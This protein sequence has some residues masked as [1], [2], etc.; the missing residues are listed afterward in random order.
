LRGDIGKARR[1]MPAKVGK[2]LMAL[3]R[4][5]MT[6]TKASRPT[7]CNTGRRRTRIVRCGG[8]TTYK[9]S[10]APNE[11]KERENRRSRAFSSKMS[12]DGKKRTGLSRRLKR[13]RE[14]GLNRRS[15]YD[16]DNLAEAKALKVRHF[17]SFYIETG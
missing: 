16:K 13:R 2:L 17:F 8:R 10:M 3:S 4:T 7:R 5:R 14:K 15:D 9:S 11:W 1:P 12:S 6:M